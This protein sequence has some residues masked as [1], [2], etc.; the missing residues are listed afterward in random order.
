MVEYMIQQ[1]R[2]SLHFW[3]AYRPSYYSIVSVSVEDN[4]YYCNDTN[5][6]R[7][8]AEEGSLSGPLIRAVNTIA[9]A[10]KDEYPHV[11][12][13]TLAY[14][15]AQEPP[16]QTKPSSDVLIRL[17]PI[18]QNL[19]QPLEHPTNA[20]SLA[21]LKAW[22]AV[23]DRIYIWGYMANYASYPQPTPVWYALG[24]T[25]KTWVANGVKGIFMEGV[26]GT[27][28]GDMDALKT[29][30]VGRLMW[31]P[32]LDPDAL[33]EQFLTG[34]FGPA[35]APFVRQYLDIFNAS[36]TECGCRVG[37]HEYWSAHTTSYLFESLFGWLMAKRGWV[38]DC[39]ASD[40]A[41]SHPGRGRVAGRA[42][43][44]A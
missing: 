21:Q 40:A 5:E 8:Y 4:G 11:R 44:W 32:T 23:S 2:R 35:A 36:A 26:Y 9:A 43:F 27:S 1:M 41:G 17:A 13:S 3:T 19:G 30:L 33:I 39:A 10:L 15:F 16:K 29:F 38:Q 22:G 34:Y 7:I 25:I 12:V 18:D 20:A 31:E 14:S 28:G 24:P 42:V 37:V 6:Q